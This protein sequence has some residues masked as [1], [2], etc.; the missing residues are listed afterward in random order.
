MPFLNFNGIVKDLIDLQNNPDPSKVSQATKEYSNP[1]LITQNTVSDLK[2]VAAGKPGA[3]N[4]VADFRKLESSHGIPQVSSGNYIVTAS[5]LRI[6]SG[7]GLSYP[8]I[9]TLN[10][11]AEVPV[12]SMKNG[13]AEIPTSY[14]LLR[15]P[16]HPA[17]GAVGAWVS[18][19]YLKRVATPPSVSSPSPSPGGATPSAGGATTPGGAGSPAGTVTDP[20]WS[21]YNISED[22]FDPSRPAA[23]EEYVSR[24]D[25]Y[26]DDVFRKFTL[27]QYNRARMT[28][29]TNRN[30]AP[31][32]YHF[33]FL[34]GP[35]A[36]TEDRGNEVNPIK[37]GGGYFVLRSGPS[38]TRMTLT[39]YLLD[40]QEADERRT[41][42]EE[43]Y[44]RYLIDRI[45]AFHEYFNESSLVIELNDYRYQ[46]IMTNLQLTQTSNMMFHYRYTMGLLVIS[47]EPITLTKKAGSSVSNTS[48]RSPR[49]EDYIKAGALVGSILG[50]RTILRI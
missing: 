36:V 41:F 19:E 8:V 21:K 10:K 17:T 43:Y 39:G 23:S 6:R 15:Q 32:V 16:G 5:V 1:F 11:G 28:V 30:G 7:P 45:N 2:A 14:T 50:L 35:N 22:Y 31:A 26:G 37:T 40:S 12:L 46:C 13:W 18:A 48:S 49:Y 27:P 38:L 24:R 25:N 9:G 42:L 4:I 47:Q 44:Q 33:E 29:T 20:N 3:A 34:I